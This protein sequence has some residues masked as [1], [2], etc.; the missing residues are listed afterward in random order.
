MVESNST[1]EVNPIISPNETANK[2]IKIE[3]KLDLTSEWDLSLNDKDREIYVVYFLV[4][5]HRNFFKF[6]CF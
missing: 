2:K 1:G 4:T 6:K 5:S 3:I